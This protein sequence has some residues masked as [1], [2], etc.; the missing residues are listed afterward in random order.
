M[1]M[2][3]KERLGMVLEHLNEGKSYSYLGK[4]YQFDIPKLKYMFKLYLLHGEAP[5]QDRR[6][7]THRRDTK[8]LAISRVEKGESIRAVASDLGLLDPGI[9]TDWIEL[10]R[11]KGEGAIQDTNARRNYRNED[12]RYKETIDQELKEKVTQLEAEIAYLKKSQSLA[13]NL[14]SLT[15]KRKSKIITELRNQYSLEV[16]LDI[17]KMPA[18]VYHYHQQMK[19]KFFH[20]DLVSEKIQELHVKKHFRKAGYQVSILNSRNWVI[21]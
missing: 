13:L 12:E 10:Y 19:P 18:S 2:T 21:R 9:L 3:L 14:E 4:K 5:F 20:Y 6:K 1:R 7:L 17:I 16:L 15:A 8:L 11:L